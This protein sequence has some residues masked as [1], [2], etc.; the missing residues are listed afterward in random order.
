MHLRR[1]KLLIRVAAAVA[2]RTRAG[3]VEV[4]QIVC[5]NS[6]RQLVEA[7]PTSWGVSCCSVRLRSFQ[8]CRAVP[9]RYQVAV[10]GFL[11]WRE[12][13]KVR[14]RS[15]LSTEQKLTSNHRSESGERSLCRVVMGD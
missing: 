10:V 11:G 8:M 4:L 13:E 3:A 15:R 12:R 1:A 6:F 14:K 2:L 9:S 7:E 5:S